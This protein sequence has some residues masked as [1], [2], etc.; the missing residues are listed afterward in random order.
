MY[1][2]DNKLHDNCNHSYTKQRFT[3]G[4]KIFFAFLLIEYLLPIFFNLIYIIDRPLY[5]L[6]IH[7]PIV[8]VKILSLIVVSIISL[9]ITRYTPTVTLK[10]KKFHKTTS[11][12]VYCV[13]F[14]ISNNSWTSTSYKWLGSMALHNTNV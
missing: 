11:K 6:P 5:R 7:S 4:G 14:A 13:V 10:K 1:I 8:L 3:K 9:L 2:L 12:V